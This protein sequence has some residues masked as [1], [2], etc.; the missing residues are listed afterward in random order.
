M[1]LGEEFSQLITLFSQRKDKIDLYNH[2]YRNFEL[3]KLELMGFVLFVINKYMFYKSDDFDNFDCFDYVYAYTLEKLLYNNNFDSTKGK[4]LSY[5]YT[6]IRNGLSS[7][8][9]NVKKNSCYN[10]QSFEESSFCEDYLTFKDVFDCTCYFNN[11]NHLLDDETR[12]FL[13]DDFY[14]IFKSCVSVKDIQKFFSKNY[15]NNFM[16][17]YFFSFVWKNKDIIKEFLC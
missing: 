4:F 15:N 16:I 14:Y 9:H 12:L 10:L 6:I 11:S 3:F 7:F 2:Y 13:R 1:K 8:L 5:V 17:F